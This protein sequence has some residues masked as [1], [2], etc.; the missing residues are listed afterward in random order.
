[1][2]FIDAFLLVVMLES[3]RIILR[4][5]HALLALSSRYR[6]RARVAYDGT[7]FQ[8]F[9]IQQGS[10]R[11][12]VQGEVEQVL[13]QRLN[14]AVRVV[15]TVCLRR[16]GVQTACLSRKSHSLHLI[17]SLCVNFADAG[18]HARGQAVHFDCNQDLSDHDLQQVQASVE[19]MLPTD[20][21]LWNLQP[22]PPP[23][24]KAIKGRVME[25]DWSVMYDSTHKLYS[26]RLSVGP[27]MDPL[28]RHYRWH[29]DRVHHWFDET[30]FARLLSYYEG[31][32]DFRAFASDVEK[33]EKR[34]GGPVDTTR[35]VYSV[36]I[37]QEGGRGNLRIDFSLKGALYKQ[38]R[39]M[40]G[41]ALNVLQGRISED[42]FR[43]LISNNGKFARHDNRSKP[44]P[45]Q[46][47]T[48]EHVY[49]SDDDSF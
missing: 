27:A 46:G 30:T 41:T 11:R 37:T 39:N 26:Y 29:P 12:T 20:V 18:V 22:V 5:V 3:G 28:E 15:A 6:Y 8:G 45:P 48:L 13:S 47:L 25:K 42:Y 40:V 34:L 9:Q 33:L 31:S 38:V 36:K 4:P 17:M 21:A 49:F 24:T 19:K 10:K 16:V 32:H 23:V 14:E 44:A 7:N 1:M 2:R 43:Q 35:T